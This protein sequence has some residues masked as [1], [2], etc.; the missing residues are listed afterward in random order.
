M[1]TTL[2]KLHY[3]HGFLKFF[4]SY[5]PCY[6]TLIEPIV[7][8]LGNKG[9]WITT[10]TAIVCTVLRILVEYSELVQPK[11][12]EPFELHMQQDEGHFLAALV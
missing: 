9:G 10:H 5:I 4:K 8:L 6:N 11:F 12:D 2:Y 7:V 3:L 1:P